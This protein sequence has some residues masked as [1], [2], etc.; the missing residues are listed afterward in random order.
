MSRTLAGIF[1]VLS[2][3]GL[4]RPTER[5]APSDKID[6]GE[7]LGHVR[8]L[9]DVRGN[10]RSVHD[11]EGYN[12][13]VLVFVSPDCPMANRYVP[14]LIELEARYRPRRVKF[15]AIY[16]NASNT[17]GEIAAHADERGV[18]FMVAKDFEQRLA[19]E[20]AIDRTPS[21]AVLDAD[22]VL[23]YRGRID[24]RL[25]VAAARAEPTHRDL[26]AALDE[27]LKGEAVTTPETAAD[28]CLL[29]RDGGRAKIENVTYAK[30]IAPILQRRCGACHQ[31]GQMAP[32]ALQSYRDVARRKNMIAEVV[33]QRRMPPWQ[34]DPRYGHFAGDRSMTD[35]EIELLCSWVEAGAPLGDRADLPPA[36]DTVAAFEIAA[37]DLEV[38][39]P[40]PVEIPTSGVM[41]DLYVIVDPGL[42]E[43]VWVQEAE[44][45]PGDA[46]VVH[47]CLVSVLPPREGRVPGA[48]RDVDLA[49][50]TPLVNWV[51]GA[52]RMI[53][54]TGVAIRL[55][56]GSWLLFDMH[57]APA[58]IAT[59]DRTSVALRMATQP[60]AREAHV[61]PLRE[62]DLRIAA[63]DPHHEEKHVYGF[64]GD[65]HLLSLRPHMHYRG[66][67]WRFEAIYPDGRTETVL[68]VPNWD[69]HWQTEY[70]FAEPLAMPKGTRLVS[71]ARWDNSDNNLNNPDP[72]VD[73]AFGWQSSD[74]VM[75]G[76]MKFVLDGD[77]A[78]RR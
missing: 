65:S 5:A 11:F 75:N 27:V 72:S 23:R 77:P 61:V 1:V 49:A 3:L 43:D 4:A 47:H 42:T 50:A 34:A 16:P 39:L 73:L 37:P 17:L 59:R 76:W 78:G 15:I 53:N 12:A 26:E 67:S 41:D 69:F 44:V 56:K 52:P 71:T 30:H 32:F 60:P 28:G 74:E 24:D 51:P 45:R 40:E 25:S 8:S 66:K 55:P 70:T 54:P 48:A 14:H 2:A 36:T 18:P 22:R 62:T 19:D 29:E 9:R 35:E 64:A 13:F 7:K 57:Y 46:R 20:L 33:T 38:R 68:S 63:G 10:R 21:V 6:I 58:G 31:P